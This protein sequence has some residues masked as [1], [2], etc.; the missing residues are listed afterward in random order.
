MAETRFSVLQGIFRPWYI[1]VGSAIALAFAIVGAYSGVQSQFPASLPL[2]ETLIVMTNLA[3][4][5]WWGWLLVLQTLFVYALFEYIRISLPSADEAIPVRYKSVEPELK[6]GSSTRV[7]WLPWKHMPH[8]SVEQFAKIT[9][10]DDPALN[11]RTTVAEA[12]IQLILSATADGTLASNGGYY[13]DSTDKKIK[14]KA[15]LDTKI[16]RADAITWAKS[17]GLDVSHIE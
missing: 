2:L 4:L 8:Y 5:P 7:T 10:K 17:K 12:Y 15:E 9:A 6:Y 1:K 14:R 16:L 11:Q 3:V 13:F